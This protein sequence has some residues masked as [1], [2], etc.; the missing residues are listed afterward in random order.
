MIKTIHSTQYQLLVNWLKE[1]RQA[2]ELTMR[3]LA[4][5]LNMP[6]S[7]IGKVEQCERKLDVIEFI[8]YCQALSLSPVD[9]IQL[10][11]NKS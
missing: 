11:L 10:I 6:H 3:D 2:Q 5:K 9:G 4:K 7:F 1:N 8:N